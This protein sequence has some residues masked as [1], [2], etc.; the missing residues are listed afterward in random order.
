M[1]RI[2]TLRVIAA[3]KAGCGCTII[4]DHPMLYMYNEREGGVTTACPRHGIKVSDHLNPG[5]VKQAY[6]AREEW[7][8]WTQKPDPEVWREIWARATE[9]L[10]NAFPDINRRGIPGWQIMTW[11]A[12]HSIMYGQMDAAGSDADILQAAARL[13]QSFPEDI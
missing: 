8:A 1:K 13:V 7:L 5:P 12:L 3:I 2:E 6:L 11:A 10:R 4:H 9:H